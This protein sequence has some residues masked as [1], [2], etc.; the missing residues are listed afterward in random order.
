MFAMRISRVE[1][2]NK[3]VAMAASAATFV[4]IAALVSSASFEFE[5]LVLV[6]GEIQSD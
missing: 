6:F 2:C 5:S 4:V 1:A 3:L